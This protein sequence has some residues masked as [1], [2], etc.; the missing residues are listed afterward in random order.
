M[1]ILDDDPVVALI[2]L[3][4]VLDNQR[5]IDA[6]VR[7]VLVGRDLPRDPRDSCDIP[8]LLFTLVPVV[9]EGGLTLHPHRHAGHATRIDNLRE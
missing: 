4:D 9:G 6:A 3:V 1:V 8:L 5:D 2:F 7:V